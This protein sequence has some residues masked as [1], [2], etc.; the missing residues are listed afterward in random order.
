MT[1]GRGHPGQN[2][3]DKTIRASQQGQNGGGGGRKHAGA[4]KLK[5][6]ARTGQPGLDRLDRKA[7]KEQS[8]IDTG[9]GQPCQES[10]RG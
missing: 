6:A 3:Y 4:G 2:R 7:G 8:G 10:R 1:A 9:S 5:L